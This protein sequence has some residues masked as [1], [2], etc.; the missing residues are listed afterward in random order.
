VARVLAAT[1][2]VAILLLVVLWTVQRRLIY[3]PSPGPVPSAGQVLPGGRDVT[4]RTIDGLHLGA[5][6]V[7]PSDGASGVT[8]LVSNGN[9]GDR[10]LRAPLARALADDGLG[11]LLYDYRGY[12]GNPGEPSEEGL[13]RD[14]RAARSYLVEEAGVEPERLLYLGESLG[15]AVVTELAAEHPPAGLVLRSPFVD[16]TSVGRV[17][18]PYLPVA[19]LLRDRFP[20]VE[21]LRNV[22]APVVVVYGSADTIV[23]ASQSRQVAA[24]APALAGSVEVEGADHND[25]ALLDGRPL[26]DAVVAL[27]R[28]VS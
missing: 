26:V 23:P 13:A 4:L 7:P 2:V 15:A 9:G 17:H 28:Q 10:S 25:L 24:A 21:H 22:R 5:W 18:Y 1:A 3:F 27:A 19:L 14:V 12:G 8:V 16:L 11:V 6:H 20:L